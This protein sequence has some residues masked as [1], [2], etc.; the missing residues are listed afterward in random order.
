[1]KG[2]VK[3]FN[4]EKGYGFLRIETG[5]PDIFVHVKDVQKSGIG[6]LKEGDELNFELKDSG[7]GRTCAAELSRA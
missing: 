4:D 3:F 5:G 6:Q 1:M 7:N 2:K